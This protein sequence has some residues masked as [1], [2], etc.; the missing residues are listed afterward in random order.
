MTRNSNHDPGVGIGPNDFAK[1]VI[2]IAPIVLISSCVILW[3]ASARWCISYARGP[4][5][6]VAS[7]GF[8]VIPIPDGRDRTWGDWGWWIQTPW[9]D[10][11]YGGFVDL[12]PWVEE[13]RQIGSLGL[14]IPLPTVILLIFLV[15]Y[16]RRISALPLETL[17]VVRWIALLV[18][19]FAWVAASR[20]QR[21]Y[22]P[23][24]AF[25]I[26]V[27]DV[28]VLTIW[29]ASMRMRKCPEGYCESCGY[30]LTGNV[31]GI[32]PECGT[33]TNS[34]VRRMIR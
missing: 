19:V 34:S 8:L 10:R 29:L 4:F 16:R 26:L 32:C 1:R 5:F 6:L 20:I 30:N 9:R 22:Y 7:D 23:H 15:C 12:I 18:L 11:F 28:V 33:T 25:A 24:P 3:T 13:T 27:M 31:S 21:A 14:H 2:A 17:R